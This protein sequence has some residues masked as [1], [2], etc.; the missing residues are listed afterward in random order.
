MPSAAEHCLQHKNKGGLGVPPSPLPQSVLEV[1]HVTPSAIHILTQS[2]GMLYMFLQDQ[3]FHIHHMWCGWL[4]LLVSTGMPDLTFASGG[5]GTQA[6][7][8]ECGGER[9][10]VQLEAAGDPQLR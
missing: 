1:G 8:V 4:K 10:V 2:E 9:Q 7:G 5:Q 3:C 6:L